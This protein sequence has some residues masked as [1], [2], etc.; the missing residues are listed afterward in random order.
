MLNLNS[1]A[2][3]YLRLKVKKCHIVDLISS[4]LPHFFSILLTLAQPLSAPHELK[5]EGVGPETHKGK[6]KILKEQGVITVYFGPGSLESAFYGHCP[7]SQADTSL[8]LEA[9]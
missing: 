5:Q 9:A 1:P 2:Q 6:G 8:L 4:L 3:A 7:L